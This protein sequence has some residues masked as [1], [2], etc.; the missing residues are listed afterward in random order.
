MAL[1]LGIRSHT[2]IEEEE[3]RRGNRFFMKINQFD[4]GL[5]M[6]KEPSHLSELLMYNKNKYTVLVALWKIVILAKT[7]HTDI[8][9]PLIPKIMLCILHNLLSWG[10]L[11]RMNTALT[12]HLILKK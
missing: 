10:L 12:L 5:V 2:Y 9:L 7:F 6:E 11:H 8:V 1:C 3:C 4:L